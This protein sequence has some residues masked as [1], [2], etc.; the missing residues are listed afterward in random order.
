MRNQRK[1]TS[2]RGRAP[3]LLAAI[4][5]ALLA[6]AVWAGKLPL[7]VFGLYLLASMV[8]FVAYALDKSA[9]RNDRRRTPDRTLHVFS[10]AGGWPGALIAQRLLRHK[11]QKESFRVVF[12]FTVAIN[13]AA[14][15]W[16][17]S[18][19]GARALRM[20]LA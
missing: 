6:G 18:P 11:T 19:S 7:V 3:L 12:W 15:A 1:T 10:L 8:A 14:L 20:V 4:F 2:A 17:L 9:A 5:L 13:C 16:L